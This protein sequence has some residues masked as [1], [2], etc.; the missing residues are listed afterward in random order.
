MALSALAFDLET[1]LP[2][3]LFLLLNDVP[4]TIDR[5]ISELG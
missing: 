4:E 2:I 3:K 5:A 1:A